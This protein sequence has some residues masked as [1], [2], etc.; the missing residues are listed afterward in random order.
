M[1]VFNRPG[2]T[3]RVFEAVRAARPERLLV[4]ADGP[5]ATRQGEADRCNAV[6]AIFDRVDWP[7]EVERDFAPENLGCRSRVSSGL[8]WVFSRAE[9]AIVVE[10]DCLPDPTFFQFCD[11]LLARYREDARVMAI[12][13]DNFQGGRRRGDAS[14]YFSRYMHV[15]GW[16]SWR[17]AWRNYDVTMRTWP[18][19]RRTVWLEGLLGD[20]RASRNWSEI[21]DRTHVGEIGTWDY[22]WLYAIWEQGGLIA[23]PNVNLVENIG[24]GADATHT[25]GSTLV[26]LPARPLTLPVVHPDAVVRSDDADRHVEHAVFTPTVRARVG[27]V[28]QRLLRRRPVR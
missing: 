25:Q 23:T 19:R 17:R 5:R 27:A 24:G 20:R 8:D 1:L 22:Q 16:A 10:D 21:F 28:L 26:G 6:R 2:P 3:A 14:Y 11:E 13:G 4:V 12:T 9:E 15:W 7:C 18:E